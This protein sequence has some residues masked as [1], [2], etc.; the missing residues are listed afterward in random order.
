MYYDLNL[1]AH[2]LLVLQYFQ[3]IYRKVI[4]T[5]FSEHLP[6]VCE[7]LG[8]EW[9][10]RLHLGFLQNYRVGFCN[11]ARLI[12]DFQSNFQEKDVIDFLMIFGFGLVDM[13]LKYIAKVLFIKQLC[14]VGWVFKDMELFI[15]SFIMI[16]KKVLRNYS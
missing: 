10:V 6:S 9:L 15:D 13:C 11:H 16:Q 2:F 5:P 3:G 4:L 1:Q 8:T 14:L 7:V 12:F